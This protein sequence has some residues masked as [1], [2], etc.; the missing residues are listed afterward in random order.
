MII[1]LY[2]P[3]T[4]PLLYFYFPSTNLLYISRRMSH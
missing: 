1:Y 2:F 3:S 4:N